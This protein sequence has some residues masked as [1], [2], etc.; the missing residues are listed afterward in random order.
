MT[1]NYGSPGAFITLWEDFLLDNV[2]ETGALSNWLETATSSGA[3]TI[4]DLHGGWWRMTVGANDDD[5][6][7]LGAELV[8]EV[9]EGF[10][11][12]WETRVQVTDVSDNSSFLGM[13][14]ANNDTQPFENQSGTQETDMTDG[15]GF[16]IEGAEDETWDAV[17]VQNGTLNTAVPQTNGAD[18]ADG[19]IQVLRMEANPNDSGTVQYFVGGAD[20]MGGGIAT[21][22]QTNWFRSGI[23][24]TP[25]A[26]I[27]ARNAAN[28]TDMDYIFVQA[29][30]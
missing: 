5:A 26:A 14:D 25:L 23:L 3:G 24:Y 21:S 12:V 22:I 17:G 10:P 11:L 7:T 29:P 28:D 30:R 13:G 6:F 18:A 9:D 15:F 27:D 4:R 8:W 16:L 2:S 20:A 19:V 1:L